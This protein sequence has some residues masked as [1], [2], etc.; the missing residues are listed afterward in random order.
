MADQKITDLTSL[1]GAGSASTD[2]AVVV[3]VSDT[4]MAASGTDKKMTL[5]E[6][7]SGLATHGS[8]YTVG[9]TDVAVADGGTGASDAAT[10]RTNLG[11]AIGTNVQAYDAELAALASTTSAADKVPYFTGS[12]TATTTDLTS[13]ARTLLDDTTVAAMRTTLQIK[14]PTQQVLTVGSGTYTTPANCTAIIVEGVASG[15]GGGGQS[16]SATLAGMGSGGGAGGYFRKLIASP[17][18]TYAYTVGAKGTG[19]ATSSG[20]AGNDTTFGSGGSLLT[21]KA[22][23]A[24]TSTGLASTVVFLNGGTGG[25][26][27]TGGD[28][29]VGGQPGGKGLRGSAT[30][31]HGGHGGDS[32]FGAGGFGAAENAAGGAAVGYG[33]GGGGASVAS[34]NTAR[35][36]GDGA[37]G[38]IIVT[39]FYG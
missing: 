14:A 10:A 9:G 26:V 11:L 20:T 19:G 34:V 23:A 31:A 2:L 21:A 33:A 32:I 24:G 36:G 12:G 4:T 30:S 18:G 29:N 22:G 5:T 15:G 27:S 1:T 35:A 38:V 37:D 3:D 8:Y 39:E 13:A 7:A 16:G 25:A 17:A 6:L 28:V